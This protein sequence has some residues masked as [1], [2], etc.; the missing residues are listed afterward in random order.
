MTETPTSHRLSNR[1]QSVERSKIRYMFDRAKAH[2]SDNLIH[3]EIGEPDFD[4][5]DHIVTA[6]SEAAHS[7]ATH[8]TSNAGLPELREAIAEKTYRDNGVRYDPETQITVTVG[9]MEA[10]HLALLA[11]ADTGDRVVIPSPSWP[12]YETQTKLAGA[13]PVEVPLSEESGFALNVD[14]LREAIDGDTA[15]VVLCSPS[16]PTGQVYDTEAVRAAVDIAAAHGAYVIA[17]EVYEGLVYQGSSKGIAAR[18][19]N[20]NHVLTVSSVSKK[21]AMTGWRLGWLAGPEPVIDVVTTIHESTTACAASP[22]QHAAL[23]AI[24]GPQGP[25][26]RM[27]EAFQERRDFVVDRI[28][29]IPELSCP[30]PDGAFY[31]FVDVGA[32]DGTSLEIAERLLYEYDVV[33][34]P[35]SGFGDA[36]EGYIRLSFAN[37]LDALELGLDRIESMVRSEVGR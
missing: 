37:S 5:P 17:D 16:N 15:A 14:R 24:T 29:E 1:V 33:V 30:S 27:L 2:D 31:A 36:G 4:T 32:L 19:D 21:Y 35:G 28:A 22:S 23:A 9:A 34:A 3:L 18:A 10:L 20:P 11:V 13:I 26:E 6:A 7:G 25:A 12:N 8:Y